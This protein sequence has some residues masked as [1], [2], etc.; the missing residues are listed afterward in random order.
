MI[1]II[2]DY[3]NGNGLCTYKSF[4]EMFNSEFEYDDMVLLDVANNSITYLIYYLGGKQLPKQLRDFDCQNNYIRCLP[5]TLPINLLRLNCSANSLSVLPTLPRN[6][7]ELDCSNCCLTSLPELP[8]KLELL[9][10][11]FNQITQLPDYIP[12]TLK[13]LNCSHNKIKALPSLCYGLNKL[14]CSFN[15]LEYLPC[16]LPGKLESLDC[17]SNNID[18]LPDLPEDLR[19]L[20][21]G[22]NKLEYLPY[23]PESLKIL[24][25]NGNQITDIDGLP[26]TLE[27]LYLNGNKID[28]LYGLPSGLKHLT[29]CN[30]VID[31]MTFPESLEIL[32]CDNNNLHEFDRSIGDCNNLRYVSCSG[33]PVQDKINRYFE[34]FPFDEEDKFKIFL[35]TFL[36]DLDVQSWNPISPYSREKSS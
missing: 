26:D 33:N 25:C 19:D 7:T 21:C 10:C 3:I 5:S 14:N 1:T 27:E 16:H 28:S 4:N 17:Q 31:Y 29:C 36:K 13:E 2:A 8:S 18:E 6:L 20:Y 23:F 22:N 30:N 35:T 15:E 34:R 9:N 32:Y 12:S 11:S 24:A